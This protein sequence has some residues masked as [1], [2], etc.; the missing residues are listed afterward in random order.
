MPRT[1]R[2]VRKTAVCEFSGCQTVTEG[3]R[4]L[5]GGSKENSFNNRGLITG[6]AGEGVLPENF[7]VARWS[8]TGQEGGA[9]ITSC[10]GILDVVRAEGPEAVGA[11]GGAVKLITGMVEV[12]HVDLAGMPRTAVVM[13]HSVMAHISDAIAVPGV[14]LV[15]LE[16]GRRRR[17]RCLCCLLNSIPF[18]FP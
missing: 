12:A 13:G 9:I 2:S 11:D 5:K 8:D 10:D 3:S 6:T 15:P 14:T 18:F 16:T 4:F 17:C 1:K 7:G